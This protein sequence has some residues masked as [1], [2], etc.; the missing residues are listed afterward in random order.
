MIYAI[1]AR[2]KECNPETSNLITI[3]I[4]SKFVYTRPNALTT[5]FH[6][7]LDLEIKKEGNNRRKS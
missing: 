2:E 1:K 4:A 5:Y 7:L 3:P 6:F